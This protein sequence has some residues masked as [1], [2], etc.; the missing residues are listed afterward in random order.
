MEQF[1]K[2]E[3]DIHTVL[4][5][6]D[7]SI[8]IWTKEELDKKNYF[9]KIHSKVPG[10]AVIDYDKTDMV[11]IVKD[12]LNRQHTFIE[13]TLLWR[14]IIF[15]MINIVGLIVIGLMV[16][17]IDPNIEPQKVEIISEI[18]KLRTD[19][20]KLKTW[21]AATSPTVTKD[22]EYT[23]ITPENVFQNNHKNN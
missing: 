15:S 20:N 6:K 17:K 14:I 12:I 1:T 19:L 16:Y 18:N 23:P 5:I 11:P 4:V 8:A 3:E 9:Y 21:Q 7:G 10:I 22:V 13:I 2:I